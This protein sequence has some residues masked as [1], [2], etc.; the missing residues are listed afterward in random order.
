MFG[1]HIHTCLVVG[2]YIPNTCLAKL[3]IM[4][5][6]QGKYMH[7]CLV[8]IY[9]L[10]SLNLLNTC[11]T[12]HHSDA[13]LAN[14]K[15]MIRARLSTR[16]CER[17]VTIVKQQVLAKKRWR[18][19]EP[20]VA[21]ATTLP[22]AVVIDLTSPDQPSK[23]KALPAY[24]PAADYTLMKPGRDVEIRYK[25]ED[26]ERS[27]WKLARVLWFGHITE[28]WPDWRRP[29]SRTSPDELDRLVPQGWGWWCQ[30][31]PDDYGAIYA[32]FLRSRIINIA[33]RV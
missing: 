26:S 6:W 23:K 18:E 3:Y 27:E 29:P 10:G 1:K 4:Y 24:E 8:N 15:Q 20:F 13:E 22:Q 5:A 7:V 12:T 30:A 31:K 9:L 17:T 21:A 19:P 14:I 25:A 28:T 16:V 2:K 11:Y 33:I 32:F